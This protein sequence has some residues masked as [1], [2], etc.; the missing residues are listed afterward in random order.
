MSYNYL[1]E[2]EEIEL[3]ADPSVDV[4]KFSFKISDW[5]VFGNLVDRQ[6]SRWNNKT[7]VGYEIT[8]D[9]YWA[10]CDGRYCFIEK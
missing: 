10:Y 5:T 9:E 3:K 7:G 4:S 8:E 6:F 2:C 1:D